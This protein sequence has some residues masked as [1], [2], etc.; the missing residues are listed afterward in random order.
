MLVTILTKI[1]HK[2]SWL[3]AQCDRL[4]QLFGGRLVQLAAKCQKLCTTAASTVWSVTGRARLA[5]LPVHSASTT[6][7][8]ATFRQ[9][10]QTQRSWTLKDRP[11]ES[12]H[13]IT[14]VC[15]C[16]CGCVHVHSRIVLSEQPEVVLRC[17]RS[18][19]LHARESWLDAIF[20]QARGQVEL[21]RRGK[22]PLSWKSVTAAG[23]R[24]DG[25]I[26]ERSQKEKHFH[27]TDSAQSGKMTDHLGIS[28]G[29]LRPSAPG[30][31]RSQ[32]DDSDNNYKQ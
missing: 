10:G 12:S 30:S 27:L 29:G 8:S 24:P 32:T 1:L 22:S 2:N 14:V 26:R 5:L 15:G 13:C 19:G 7:S 18:D 25:G 11:Q 20:F 21:A 23:P 3:G 6:I 16:G 4:F 9:Q 17:R 28:A 31:W